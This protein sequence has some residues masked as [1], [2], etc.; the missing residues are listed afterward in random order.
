MQ[1]LN[2][3]SCYS[4]FHS[5]DGVHYSSTFEALLFNLSNPVPLCINIGLL[6]DSIVSSENFF[7]VNLF[8]F[9]EVPLDIDVIISPLLANVTIVDDDG[10]CVE[11]ISIV[12][13]CSYYHINCLRVMYKDALLSWM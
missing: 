9:S 4:L 3:C 8:P 1:S 5:V 13:V 6:D 11:C 12:Y 7:V 2:R 10:M